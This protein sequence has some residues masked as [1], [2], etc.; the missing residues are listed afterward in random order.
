MKSSRSWLWLLLIVPLA[1][2]VAR[3]RFDVEVLNLLPDR[4]DVV[5]GLKIYQENFSN[6]RELI[7]TLEGQNPDEV[8][9]CARNLARALHAQTNLVEEVTWQPAW[10]EHPDQAAELIAYLWFNQ[11]PEIFAVLTNR[12][13]GTNAIR[14]LDEARDKLATS[15]SANDIARRGYDPFNLMELPE[16]VSMAAPSIGSGEELFSSADG[17]FRVMFVEAKPSLVNYKQCRSWLEKTKAVVSAAQASAQ[18][19]TSI[20]I[21][22]TGRPAFV[23]EI[24]GGMEKDMAGSASGTLLVIGILFYLTHRRLRPLLWLLTLLLLMLG[25]TMA[26][27]GLFFGTIN[28]VSMGFAAILAGLAEDFGIVLYQESRTHPELSASDLRRAAAP[29]IVWSAI[30]TSGAFLLLNL[31]GLPGLGQLGSLV[32]IG[33]LLAAVMMLYGYLPPLLRLRRAQDARPDQ[34]D[35][36]L[37]LFAPLKLLPR[38]VI[39]LITSVVLLLCVGLL[40]QNRPRFDRSPDPLKPKNSDAYAAVE[41]IKQRLG[42]TEEPLWVMVPGRNEP[43]VANRLKRVRPWLVEAASKQFIRS[44]TLSDALWPQ[45]ENQFANRPA[46]AIL[47]QQ[48]EALIQAALAYGFTRSSLRV[49]EN[50]FEYWQTALTG[51]NIYW[52]TT[53][54]SRWV[55]EKMV[56]RSS[57]GLLALGLIHPQP[58]AAITKKFADSFPPDLRREGVILSGWGILGPTV[59]EMV[60]DEF[61]HVFVPILLLVVVSLW[62]AFRSLRDVF[63]SLATLVFSALCLWATMDL[64]KWQW[65]LLNLMALPLLLG[66]GVDYSIHIQ[67]ALRRYEGNLIAVRRSVGRALL[68]AGSTTIVGF[69]SLSFS[70]NAGMA[71]LGKVCALGLTLTL[72]TAVYLLPVWWV[73]L[74]R[75]TLTRFERKG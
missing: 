3:L 72:L 23:T 74:G 45:A 58:S 36:K 38:S 12:L 63:L 18:I 47:V 37:L 19:P 71:S 11:S 75:Q 65:N 30:T 27:G 51:T 26:F 67:L 10:M 48:K 2:G 14:A 17:T 59:F 44:F 62:L 15:F 56:G 66:M 8:E 43:E 64:L 16:S 31:S 34:P 46:L 33:I 70:T 7:L 5:R 35:E 32:A 60:V 29:G 22:Y 28:V 55:L 68:L 25:A 40:A 52:P 20:R 9:T 73:G 53:G 57:G 61:P 4:L 50:I 6:A 21:R 13:A 54:A 24:A 49:T 69:G 42:R 39:W 1:L 41:Q